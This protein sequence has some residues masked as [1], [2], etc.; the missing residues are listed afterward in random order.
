[1]AVFSEKSS[2]E[3]NLPNPLFPANTEEIR[4]SF[5]KT[6]IYFL[7]LKDTVYAFVLKQF[8]AWDVAEYFSDIAGV[9]GWM[10]WDLGCGGVFERIGNIV[11]GNQWIV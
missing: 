4:F 2:A 1:M 6:S 9:G 8:S 7:R 10:E 11:F 5:S 3:R